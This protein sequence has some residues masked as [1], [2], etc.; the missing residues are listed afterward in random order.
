MT[1]DDDVKRR[2]ALVDVVQ[3]YGEPIWPENFMD[4][5]PT[6]TNIRPYL[7]VERTHGTH[8]EVLFSM[9]YSVKDALHAAAAEIY[10]GCNYPD[11]LI[12]LDNNVTHNLGISVEIMED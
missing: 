5:I 4:G 10:E 2:A 1:N 11:V 3:E 12:D 8:N 7:L 6:L 9:F